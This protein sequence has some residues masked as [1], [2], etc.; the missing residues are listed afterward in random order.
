M[1][2]SHVAIAT[3]SLL[4]ISHCKG[5]SS[6]PRLPFLYSYSCVLMDSAITLKRIPMHTQMVPVSHKHMPP[7][8]L[9]PKMAT[10]IFLVPLFFQNLTTLPTK[11]WSLILLPLYT[12]RPWRLPSIELDG[13]KVTLH[14]FWC[15]VIIFHLFVCG[16][17]PSLPPSIPVS[18]SHPL[19]L[20]QCTHPQNPASMWWGRPGHTGGYEQTFHPQPALPIGHVTELAFQWLQPP[21]FRSS[22]WGIV[23]IENCPCHTMM[24]L[25][26]HRIHEHNKW[27]FVCLQAW[28]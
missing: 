16:L 28:G 12:G 11:R 18:L 24:E 26:A 15:K 25:M 19:P 9:G 3:W 2:D 13:A 1:K 4:I 22:S 17:S 8:V 23:R 10:A 6:G 14:A 20:S 21:A 5:W 7:N 27:L